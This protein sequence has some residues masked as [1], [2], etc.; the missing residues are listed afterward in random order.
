MDCSTPGFP[1]LHYLL[2]LLKLMFI[3]SVMPS[4]HLILFSPLVLLPLIFPSIMVFS[5]ESVLCIRWPKY[6]SIVA[7][8]SVYKLSKFINILQ[9]SINFYPYTLYMN[10]IFW[11]CRFLPIAS[12]RIFNW[13]SILLHLGLSLSVYDIVYQVTLFQNFINALVIYFYVLNLL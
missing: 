8:A 4:S 11:W 12:N 10:F 13:K 5:N 2:S 6:W 7:S 9:C 3:E 1:V